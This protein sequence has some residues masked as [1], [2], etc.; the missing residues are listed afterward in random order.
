MYFIETVPSNHKNQVLF[1]ITF[2]PPS[3]CT[4]LFLF[5]FFYAFPTAESKLTM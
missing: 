3:R 5:I 2:L 1:R 4:F